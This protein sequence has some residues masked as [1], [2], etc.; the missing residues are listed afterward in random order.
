MNDSFNFRVRVSSLTGQGGV[1]SVMHP[2]I[3]TRDSEKNADCGK[4]KWLDFA[5]A[6]VSGLITLIHAHSRILTDKKIF[7]GEMDQFTREIV[8]T[9]SAF[10]RLLTGLSG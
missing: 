3:E 6:Y 1:L 9:A 7:A 2:L 8:T 5:S 4:I 10:A